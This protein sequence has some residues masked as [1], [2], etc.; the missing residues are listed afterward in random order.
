VDSIPNR[1]A[2]RA[3]NMPSS[4]S[5]PLS[6]RAASSAAPAA[7]TAA[8]CG[9]ASAAAF[10]ELDDFAD[11]ELRDAATRRPTTLAALSRGAPLVLV[12]LR[13]LGCQLCRL[14]ASEFEAARPAIAQAGGSAVCVTFEFL[15]EGS[16]ADRSWE[17][18]GAWR[19]ALLTDPTRELYRSL[20]RRKT[21]LDGSFFG[22]LDMSAR[23]A[24]ES[25]AFAKE[26]NF[27]GDGMMLGG[28]FVLDRGGRVLLDQRSKFFG[29]DVPIGEVLATLR[30][31]KGARALPPGEALVQISDWRQGEEL[32][33][34]LKTCATPQC[35]LD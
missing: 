15:G 24:A 11:Y 27:K 18:V 9:C 4:E 28:C 5:S 31:A 2:A 29:D 23:R 13:R 10:H 19:G 16:D 32:A 22:L 35:M 3:R 1:T 17:R 14:R 20:F 7:A 8:S 26:A 6:P 21:L 12:F 25:A 34:A 30:R 33:P